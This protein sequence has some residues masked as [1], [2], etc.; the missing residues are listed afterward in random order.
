MLRDPVPRWAALR[1]GEISEENK[2]LVRRELEEI[3]NQGKLE[4]AD[5]TPLAAPDVPGR[6]RL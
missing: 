6:R 4:L 2:A 5:R 1:G 3:F